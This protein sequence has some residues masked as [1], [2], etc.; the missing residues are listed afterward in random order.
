MRY[1]LCDG[2]EG[3]GD[4]SKC[5]NDL[6]GKWICVE[7]FRNEDWSCDHICTSTTGDAE[8]LRFEKSLSEQ[9]D[10]G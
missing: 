8:P 1:F 9:L 2:C 7:C 10:F 5:L 4:E 3:T 6:C